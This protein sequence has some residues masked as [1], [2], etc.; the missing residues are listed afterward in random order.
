MRRSWTTRGW[1]AAALLAILAPALWTAGCAEPRRTV[2]LDRDANFGAVETVAL[3][4]LDN[5]TSDVNAPAKVSQILTIELLSAQA[6]RVVDVGDSRAAL[7][8]MELTSTGDLDAEQIA[9]IGE[10]LGAQALLLGTVRELGVDRSAGVPAPQVSLQF[11]LVDVAS[12]KTI[13]SSVVSRSGAGTSAR[14]FGVGGKSVN[15]AIQEMVREAL[16][17][18]IR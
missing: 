13:W 6:F 15:G 12:G 9:R 8:A 16:E 11:R 5:F 2:F 3:L 17:T 7:A 10:R 14:L 18:L 4:P 1:G